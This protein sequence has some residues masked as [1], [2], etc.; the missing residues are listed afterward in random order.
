MA[1]KE[2]TKS[3]GVEG[4]H[5]LI[6]TN[7]ALQIVLVL[8]ITIGLIVAVYY[9]G[10]VRKDLSAGGPSSH[11]LSERTERILG[12]IDN[13]I[14][15]TTVYTSD[16]PEYDRREYLPK[17]RDLCDEMQQS[18]KK[19]EARHLHSGDE[20]ER[21]LAQ[22]AVHSLTVANEQQS[23]RL[24]DLEQRLLDAESG[25]KALESIQAQPPAA[26]SIS[27]PTATPAAAEP[28]TPK[29]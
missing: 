6:G 4:R 25:K 11:R 21:N 22:E 26:G 27:A 3:T 10:G 9:T 17:L 5:L 28:V 19:I 16:D 14:R 13:D 29:P 2:N 1:V 24:A 15:I 20:E 18:D 7:V 8:A 12:K 23:S